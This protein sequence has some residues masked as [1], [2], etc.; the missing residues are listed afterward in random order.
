VT[1]HLHSLKIHERIHTWEKPLACSICE[2]TFKQ[3]EETWKDP[4]RWEAIWLLHIW[5]NIYTVWRDM[6]G[7]TQVRSHLPAPFVR[8]HLHSLKRHERIHTGEKPFAWSICEKNIYTV[9]RD[10]KGS[11][12]ERSHLPVP[13]VRKHLHSLK[14]H[15]R[16]HTGEKPFACSNCEKT[17]TPFE[18]TWK[19]PL[20]WEAI[21]L[22]HK[23]Q[24]IYTVWRYM[25]G[26]T[27]ERSH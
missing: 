24:N 12:Q 6:K 1:K 19:D 2:K 22:L 15:E 3:F 16:I 23:W 14:S 21:C 10:M 8:K 7:S 13:Y 20:R 4:H 26:S 5:Q 27:H 17:F 18:E 9:W 11:T 25:K